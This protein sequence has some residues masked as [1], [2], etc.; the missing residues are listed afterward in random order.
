MLSI[1]LALA[2]HRANE[3]SQRAN[4]VMKILTIFSAFFLPLNFIVGIYG[5]NFESMPELK[6]PYGYFGVWVALI[7]TVVVIYSWFVHKGWI[8]WGH[9]S[10]V[11][12]RWNK[13]DKLL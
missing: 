8:R 4:Q 6:H 13:T 10:E 12:N 11:V 2:G 7:S 9:L 3:E 1:Q 5:M